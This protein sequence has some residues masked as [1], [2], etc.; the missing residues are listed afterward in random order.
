MGSPLDDL[1]QLRAIGVNWLY[2]VCHLQIK[3]SSIRTAY[4]KKIISKCAKINTWLMKA[5]MKG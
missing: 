5:E 3:K 4:D 1:S 2:S